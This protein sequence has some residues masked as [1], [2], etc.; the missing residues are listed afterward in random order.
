MSWPSTDFELAIQTEL[1]FL[2]YFYGAVDDYLG[3]ASVNAY[4]MIKQQYV[5]EGND[6]P[7]GY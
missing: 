1:D 3:P 6:L 4:E 5:E 7:E 2:Q